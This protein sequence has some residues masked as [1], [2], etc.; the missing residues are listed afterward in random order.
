VTARRIERVC[1]GIAAGLCLFLSA[2]AFAGGPLGPQGARV[3]T[4]GYSVDLFQGP[5]LATTRITALGGAYTAIAEGTDGIPFNPAAA[6]FRLPYSTTRDDWDLTAG[7]TIPSSVDG[8]DFD[9][10]G[11]PGFTYDNFYWLTFGGLIQHDRLGFGLMASF[12]NYELGVPGTPV[13]LPG[14]TEL[15]QSVT[16]RIARLDPVLSYGFLDD[17][18]HV[19][20]G[21]R[22]TGFYGVGNTT[23]GAG[24]PTPDIS[25]ERL[26][27]NASSLGFQGGVLWAPHALPLRVGG[28]VRSPQVIAGS[29]DGRITV[30]TNGNRVVGNLYLPSK[31]DLPFEVEAGVAVQLWKR[32]LNLP[33]YDEEKVPVPETERWRRTIKGQHESPSL[34]ARRM[35]EARYR[36]I[37][38]ERVLLTASALVSGPVANAI[39]VESMLAQTIDRSGERTVVTL[40]GG[41]E[42][43]VIPWWLVLRAG[44]YLEP[45]RYRGGASRLHATGGF[46]L[47]VLRWSVFGL[48]DEDTLFRVSFA[49][50]GAR[51]YFGWSVGAGL[52]R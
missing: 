42:A 52:F 32:R 6:S 45:T 46:A 38:R 16:A 23:P 15:I 43:E 24:A 41:A 25:H 12:Q 29:D 49:V 33:W 39:G 18:L 27:I 22:F 11:K 31:V 1:G 50:D 19:G 36:E 40:R 20:T 14:S 21:L 34:G 30:D 5:V 28:S 4:S 35:L 44:T 10:N 47:R 51:D 3:Q 26:L 9:N 13:P 17:Q 8:T 7:L 2:D 48:L 37:P